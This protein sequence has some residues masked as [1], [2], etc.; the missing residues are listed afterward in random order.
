MK[1]L[2]LATAFTLVA[3]TSFA[4]GYS[5][6]IVTPHVVAE[7]AASSSGDAWVMAM[8]VFITIGLG[9]GG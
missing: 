7:D 2:I 1:H 4:D 6:P 3:S 9:L 8:M 5:D